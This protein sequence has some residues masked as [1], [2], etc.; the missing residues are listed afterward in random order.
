MKTNI[1]NLIL[2]LF[3]GMLVGFGAILPGVS[4]GTLCAAFGMYE[5]IMELLAHPIKEIKRNGLSLFFFIAGGGL[6]FVGLSGVAARLMELDSTAVIFV[7]IGLICGTLPELWHDAGK[8]GRGKGSYIALAAGFTVLSV[9]LWLLG[10]GGSFTLTPD[11]V[12]YLVCGLLW[13][14]SFTVP[15]LSSS[16]LI[17][18][19]GLYESMLAGISSLSMSVLI[20]LGIGTLL[21]L[22]I[23]PKLTK[24]AFSRYHAVLSHCVIGVVVASTV[25]VLPYEAFSTVKGGAV[26]LAYAAAGFAAARAFAAIERK[27]SG[28]IQ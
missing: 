12:G 13:G 9:L 17:M 11:F 21:C 19:F 4:G 5:P 8:E 26:A 23:L 25:A 2:L 18:F 10:R 15:G 7:F 24:A 28:Q 3:K 14:L 6:G 27:I 16:T 22:A 20:P 1:I